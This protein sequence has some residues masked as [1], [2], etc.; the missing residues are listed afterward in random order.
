MIMLQNQMIRS[1]NLINRRTHQMIRSDFF[2][3]IKIIRFYRDI[4]FH[5]PTCR[6][7]SRRCCDLS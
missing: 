3:S 5:P 1:R 2:A 6:D 7:E 4:L